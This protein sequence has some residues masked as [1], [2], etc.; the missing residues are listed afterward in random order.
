MHLCRFNRKI[1][2]RDLWFI[3]DLLEQVGIKAT[4]SMTVLDNYKLKAVHNSSST[5][6]EKLQE[7]DK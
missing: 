2:D 7:A 5:G 3:H 6:F 1:L 4:L